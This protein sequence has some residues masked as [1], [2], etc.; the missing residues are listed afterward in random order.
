MTN[1]DAKEWR[2]I[3]NIHMQEINAFN[4]KKYNISLYLTIIE[5]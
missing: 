4:T 5:G 2:C 3:L 1:R